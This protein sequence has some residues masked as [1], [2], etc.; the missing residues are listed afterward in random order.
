MTK[1]V[2]TEGAADCTNGGW[3]KFAVPTFANQGQCV[4]YVSVL[5]GGVG[6]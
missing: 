3:T 1:D 4:S 5:R 6:R 2:V